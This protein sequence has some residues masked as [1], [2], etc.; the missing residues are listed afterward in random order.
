MRTY[1]MGYSEVMSLPMRTFWHLSGSVDRVLADEHKD[2]LE[3][4]AIANN[5]EAATERLEQLEKRAPSPFKL[6]AKGMVTV[7]AKRDDAGFEEL[8]MLAG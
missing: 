3:L 7:T 4:S 6:S 2:F 8:R 1:R 5:P